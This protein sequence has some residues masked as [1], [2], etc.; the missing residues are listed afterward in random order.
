VSIESVYDRSDLIYRAIE[1]LKRTLIEESA[2]VALVCVVFLLHVR[3]ALVAIITLHLYLSAG[4][5][6]ALQFKVA[7]ILAAL[8]ILAVSLWPSRRSSSRFAA[9]SLAKKLTP[10]RLPPGRARLATR[11]SLTGSSPTLKTIGIVVVA[12]LA[13]NDEPPP[14]TAAITATRRRTKSVASAGSRSI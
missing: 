13:A 4:D 7:T 5:P 6:W 10:V 1:T 2:I 9:N 8:A 12:D 14:P 3:S 11:P